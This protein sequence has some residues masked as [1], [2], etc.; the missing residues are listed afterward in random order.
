MR[1]RSLRRNG[2]RSKGASGW[3]LGEGLGG[4]RDAYMRNTMSQVTATGCFNRIAN[5]DRVSLQWN[6]RV[7]G[8]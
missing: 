8:F 2:R 7:S 3:R 6:M 5:K 1:L 4:Y